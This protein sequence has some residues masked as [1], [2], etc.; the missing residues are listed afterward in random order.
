MAKQTVMGLE[1]HRELVDRS[2]RSSGLAWTEW[3][4]LAVN[5]PLSPEV[6]LSALLLL[7]SA[8]YDNSALT[9]IDRLRRR[10]LPWD[11]QTSTLALRIA[12]AAEFDARRAGV[13]LRAAQQVCESGAGTEK[14]LAAVKDLRTVLMSMPAPSEVL[15]PMNYW[16]LPETLNLI[17]RVLSTATPPDILDLAVLRDGDDWGPAARDSAHTF[18]AAAIA[19]LVRA[20]TGLGPGKP[21]KS[22]YLNVA[23]GTSV[24]EARGLLRQW[25]TLA[26]HADVVPP[27]EHAK[28][29]FAG[30]MLFAMGNDD[31]VR[32]A[33]F[34]TRELPDEDW[35]PELLGILARRGAATSG[36]PGMTGALALSVASAAVDTLAARA[37]PADV[38]ILGELFEDLTRRDLVKRVAKHL[39]LDEEVAIR[40]DRELRRTKAAAV[41][42]KADPAPRQARAAMDVLIRRHFA[43]ILKQRGFNARGRTFRRVCPDR[44]DVIAIGSTGLHRFHL[45]FGTRFTTS[46][47]ARELLEIDES[48]TD[49]RHSENHGIEPDDVQKLSDRLRQV[50]IPFLDSMGRYEF[51]KAFAENGIGAPEGSKEIAGQMGPEMWGVL[52]LLA[53]AAGD[54]NTAVYLLTLKRDFIRELNERDA[55]YEFQLGVWNSYLETASNLPGLP[56]T[57]D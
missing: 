52:G 38:A 17:E 56:T 29:G 4:E 3:P 44:V 48:G 11:A 39:E 26:A 22:W 24:P 35:V 25:L 9:V 47:P 50:V 18:P 46:W 40:R 30:A 1:Y 19:P 36:V 14:L 49:I 33:V 55:R 13:A 23:A 41:S 54:R 31:V 34:A 53:L 6:R 20:L 21:A 32:A 7:L 42:R 37:A 2:I 57:G 43:P 45:S 5:E 28:V 27:D 12:A 15:G 51:V 8:P 16:Q 10:R